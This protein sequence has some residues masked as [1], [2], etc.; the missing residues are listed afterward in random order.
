MKNLLD[1]FWFVAM[2]QK[3]SA[4]NATI[5]LIIDLDG[6]LINTDMLHEST[7]QLL[8]KKPLDIFK[9]PFWLLKGKAVLKHKIAVL[10]QIE[11]GLLPYNQKLLTWL[12]EQREKGRRLILCTASNIVFAN[13]IAKY[14]GIFDEVIASDHAVNLAGEHK[15]L[16]LKQHFGETG[17]DYAGNSQSDIAVW[18]C[19]RR[20]IIVNASTHVTKKAREHCEV[21]EIFPPIKYTLSV[22]KKLLRIHQWLK[23]ALLFAPIIAAH[24]INNP[25]TWLT[26]IIAFFSFSFCASSVY[27]INDLFDLDSD[28]HHPRKRYRPLASGTVSTKVGIM[29]I[30]ILLSLSVGLACLVNPLFLKWLLFYFTVTCAYS[31]GLKRLVLI[32]CLTLA[33]L[34]TIRILAGSAAAGLVL[35]F[36]LIAFSV[37]LFLSLAFVKRYAELEMQILK[38]KQKAHGRSYYTTD[39]PLIQTMGITSGYAAVLVLALYLNSEDVLRL[40]QNTAFVCGAVPV[41]LFWISWMWLQAHR[42]KMHD[43]PLIFAMKDKVSLLSGMVFAGV[44]VIG[45]LGWPW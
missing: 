18:K 11:P 28:R 27:I 34:Y 24:Q 12:K 10:T 38:G 37:F 25:E 44:L 23:N 42:G 33:M 14:L 19:A 9:I 7:L 1:A 8:K 36:W 16:R 4:L 31:F 15:A 20:A 2:T 35:S 40:Y 22:G 5:P 45:T 41:M 43:D 30:P 13:A 32:D 29:L 6:T 3:G 21:E 17:F 26:L 39:A